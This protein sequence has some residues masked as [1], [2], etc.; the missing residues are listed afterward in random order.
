[1]RELS[2]QYHGLQETTRYLKTQISDNQNETS[3][4]IE[5]ERQKANDEVSKMRDA[6]IK[7]LT[8]ERALMKEQIRKTMDHVRD[9]LAQD[10][11]E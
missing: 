1:M 8:R 4:I 9:I 3:N 5:H 2:R 11:E 7:V 6:M 10:E